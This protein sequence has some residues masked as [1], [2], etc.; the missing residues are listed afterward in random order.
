M[1]K[2]WLMIAMLAGLFTTAGFA[3]E[4]EGGLKRDP[5]EMFKKIDTD[6]DGKISKEEAEKGP[7]GRLKENF[8]AIDTNKDSYLDKEELKA[9]RQEKKA[10]R[11]TVKQK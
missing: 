2:N 3:Q 8:T 1:N 10:A 6:A 4:K 11:K 5:Q 7:K 9:Y